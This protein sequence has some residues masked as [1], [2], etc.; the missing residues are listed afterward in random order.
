M[1]N[2]HGLFAAVLA[3][4]LA[5]TTGTA[6]AVQMD[7]TF[8]GDGWKTISFD[9]LAAGYNFDRAYASC[10]G[11]N[12]TQ[13]VSGL[14]RGGAGSDWIG[15]VR[16]LPDGSLDPTFGSN[17]RQF[18]ALSTGAANPYIHA[19]L[20]VG[21]GRT[22]I[23]RPVSGGSAGDCAMDA[24]GEC[25]LQLLRI[26]DQ[27]QLDPTFGSGGS[28]LLDLDTVRANLAGDETP[29]GLNRAANGELLVTG[30]AQLAPASGV[31]YRPFIA[32]FSADG[33]PAGAVVPDLPGL[34]GYV[35]A[36][37]ADYGP[38]GG[39]WLVGEGKDAAG[40]R[41]Y[42]LSVLDAATLQPTATIRGSGG[43]YFLQG[44]RMLRPG[45]F[46]AGATYRPFGTGGPSTPRL[47]VF[48]QGG[49]STLDL[50]PSAPVDGVA[51]GVISGAEAIMALDATHVLYNTL[52]AK[53]P[54]DQWSYFAGMHIALARIGASAAQDAALPN[55]AATLSYRSPD[56]SCAG[57]AG[58]QDKA[59]VSLW[60]GLPVLV[61]HAAHT[62]N[63]ATDP[64]WL[65]ARFK[66][67]Y[68]FG[69]GFE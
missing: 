14:A 2:R 57:H 49:I 21:G 8:D 42:Y 9:P 35:T 64:D 32:R 65:L 36:S 40:Q 10:P 38:N 31:E 39:V 44:A 56:A 67:D 48:R 23:A 30:Y 66:T 61:G 12:G 60:N 29:L 11:P 43:D 16:L 34:S 47:V 1:R 53:R 26:T 45:V 17:G 24:A 19:A 69:N 63:P 58:D 13:I 6:Q 7:T 68:L 5:A 55:D 25:N 37:A 20:C 62:C 22:V 51:T 3:A 52:I 50:P 15:V 18:I 4:T 54:A 33:M 28:T 46:V 41:V 59:R 27:G